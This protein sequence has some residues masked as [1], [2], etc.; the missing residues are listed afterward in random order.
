MWCKLFINKSIMGRL[1]Y[2]V[3]IEREGGCERGRENVN[4][5]LVEIHEPFSHL[6]L[7]RS[8]YM[9]FISCP[10]KIKICFSSWF[11]MTS[12]RTGWSS[13]LFPSPQFWIQSSPS[14]GLPSTKHPVY[15]CYL[16]HSWGENIW[17]RAF[18]SNGISAKE[19]RIWTQLTSFT[20]ITNIYC[21]TDTSIYIGSD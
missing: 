14:S 17:I 15:F 11:A 21:T 16:T 1:L 6:S 13:L 5:S 2:I 12:Y 20:L 9:F 18:F 8:S 4:L 3:M 7:L 19:A 10:F